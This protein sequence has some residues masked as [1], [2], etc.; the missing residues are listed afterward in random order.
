MGEP[1][2]FSSGQLRPSGRPESVDW[3]GP[4][5]QPGASVSGLGFTYEAP[6]VGSTEADEG[7]VSLSDF[8]TTKICSHLINNDVYISEGWKHVKGK[9]CN[10]KMEFFFNCHSL[11]SF[12]LQSCYISVLYILPNSNVSL[13]R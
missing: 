10:R 12:S 1:N 9:S 4:S 5:K 6:L 2:A 11:V 3:L 13:F 8:S 7:T